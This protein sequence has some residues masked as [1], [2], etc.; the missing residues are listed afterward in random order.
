MVGRGDQRLHTGSTPYAEGMLRLY[1]PRTGQIAELA[2]GRV[3]RVHV[4]G[5]QPRL[6]VLADVIRRLADRHRHRVIVTAAADPDLLVLNVPPP[7][8]GDPAGA[9]LRVGEAG[10]GRA[11]PAGPSTGEQ[12]PARVAEQ[13][14]DPLSVRLAAL[15]RPYRE[16][17]ALD[18]P[19]LEAADHE[20]RHWRAQV[21]TWAESPS[22]PMCA[23][24]VTEALT[25][26]DEDLDTP[27]ALAVL[28]R[29]DEDTEIPPGSKFETFS[30]LD[31][32]LALDLVRDIGR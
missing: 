5:P 3:L 25:S 22:K 7:E 28:R 9:D 11:L 26:L 23:A 20:L 27:G 21:A 14:L 29:L 6:H 12:E 24:Y 8:P 2:A 1:D 30:S 13:G 4:A 31:M 18:R 19:A 15:R 10:Q 32:V 17:L 16:P